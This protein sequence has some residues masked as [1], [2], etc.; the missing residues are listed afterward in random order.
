MNTA[1]AGEF[2]LAKLER[3]LPQ[4]LFYH[5]VHHVLDV[6]WAALSI[7][8]QESV[9]DSESLDL[10]KTAALYHDSGFISTYKNHEEEGC[11]IASE[12]LPGFGYTAEQIRII[13][14]M[15]MATKIPQNPQ[16]HLEEIICDA[17]LDYLGRDDFKT[18]G[19]TLFNELTHRGL[20]PNL[21]TWNAR[22]IEFLSAHEYKTDSSR[23]NRENVKQK[24]LQE[25]IAAQKN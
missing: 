2:I 4:D 17:D 12:V 8:A 3:D 20:V 15:I 7:A 1:A 19:Q 13:C 21:E 23:K 6:T 14:G 16:T 11:R 25:L 10:L 5:G 18:I 22:Q 9:T 24:H